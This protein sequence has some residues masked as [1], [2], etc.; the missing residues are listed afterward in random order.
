MMAVLFGNFASGWRSP[1]APLLFPSFS[2]VDPVAAQPR[3]GGAAVDAGGGTRRLGVHRDRRRGEIG[4]YA[5]VRRMGGAVAA[6]PERS[7]GPARPALA[8]GDGPRSD[9]AGR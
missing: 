6:Q 3:S 8:G 1:D 5:E 7:V 4:R 9:G 2:P